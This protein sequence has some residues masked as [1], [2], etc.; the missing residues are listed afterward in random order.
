MMA[1]TEC[2]FVNGLFHFIPIGRNKKRQ[3]PTVSRLRICLSS[4][5]LLSPINALSDLHAAALPHIQSQRLQ[6][7]LLQALRD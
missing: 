5:V 4:N 7:Q 2:S 3:S 1:W 6:V